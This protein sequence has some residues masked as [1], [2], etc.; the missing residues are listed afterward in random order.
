VDAA[1]DRFVA[2]L[3]TGK[4]MAIDMAV[5]ILKR[6]GI[7]YQ[8]RVET[9]TGLKLALPVMPTPEPGSFFSVLVQ[10]KA[11]EQAQ[12]VLSALPFEIATNPGAW[13]FG[14]RPAVKRS[15]KVLVVVVVVAVISLGVYRVVSV[16]LA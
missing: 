15:L 12:Q 13:D 6:Y 4:P 3:T 11:V 16:L 8:T 10:G 1:E 2:V 9:S 14:P 5:E 7:P